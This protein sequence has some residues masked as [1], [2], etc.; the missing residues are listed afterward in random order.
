LIE[1]LFPYLPISIKEKDMKYRIV[2]KARNYEYYPYVYSAQ[3]KLL[4]LREWCW[5]EIDWEYS[6][7]GA[8]KHIEKYHREHC[9]P[10][11]IL[12]DEIVEEIEL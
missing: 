2:K 8:R 7:E 1:P 6:L 11:P 4:W 12:S 3:R 9:M 10:Q 5:V